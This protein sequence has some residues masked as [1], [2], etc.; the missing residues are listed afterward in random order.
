MKSNSI[1]RKLFYG[2]CCLSTATLAYG[3][4]TYIW[5]NQNP[6]ASSAGNLDVSA[7][8]NPNGLPN[9]ANTDVAEWDGSTTGNLALTINSGFGGSSGQPGIQIY[10]NAS[11]TA[12]LQIGPPAGVNAGTPRW[13]GILI[14]NGAGQFVLGDNT[15]NSLEIAWGS[16]FTH[17]LENDSTNPAIV[18][19]NIKW[20]MGGGGTHFYD[21]TGTGDWIV[22]SYIDNDNSAGSGVWKGG[23]NTGTGTLYWYGTNVPNAAVSGTVVNGGLTIYNGKVVLETYNLLTTPNISLDPNQNGG[24]MMEYNA[25]LTNTSL[26]VGGPGSMSGTISGVGPIQVNAGSLSLSGFNT[27]TG[28]NYLTGGE[29]IV[30]RGE[31]L[32]VNGP[33][34]IGG[35]ISFAGGTLGYSTANSYDYSPRFDTTPGQA[36]SFDVPSGV[37]VNFAT[38]LTSSGGTLAK[39]GAGT[40]TLAAAN[41]YSGLTTVSA[42]TLVIQGTLGHG[43]IT[44]GD[45]QT[46]GVF[47]NGTPLQPAALTLGA[48]TSASLEFLNLTNTTTAPIAVSG[49]I[50]AAGPINVNVNSGVFKTIGATFPLISWGSGSAPA[51]NNP[52]TVSG[53]AGVL[54]T[55]GNSIILTI[56]ATPY[57]WTGGTSGNWTTSAT[58]NWQQSGSAIVWQNGVLTLFDDSAQ[59][60]TNVTITGDLL[61]GSVSVNNSLLQYSIASSAGNLIDGSSGLTKSGNSTLTLTGGANAYTGVTSVGGGTLI[62]S[63]LANGG[64]PSDIGAS[65]SAAANLVLNG[66][67]LQYLGSGAAINRQFSVGT[68]GGTLDSSGTGALNLTANQALGF[69]G[70]GVHTLTLTGSDASGDTLTANIGDSSGGATSLTKSGSGIWTLLGTNTYSGTTTILG[71]GEL[72]IGNG[73]GSGTIGSGNIYNDG[74]SLDFDSAATLTVNGVISGNGSLTNDGTGTTILLNNNTY[75]GATV[76]NAGTLQLG[77]GGGTGTLTGGGSITNNSKMVFDSTASFF[78]VGN[79]IHGTGNVEVK[80]GTVKYVGNND[81]TGWTLIDSGAIFTPDDNN[82][83]NTGTLSTSV[84]TN[85]GTLRLEGYTTRTAMYAN[86]VGTGK[87]QVGAT[88]ANF[89]QGDEVLGGTNTYT[90]GTYIGETHLVLGDGSTP[91]AGSIVGNVYFVNNFEDAGDGGRRLK[92]DR[93]GGDDFV[94]SGNIVTNFSSAQNNLGIVE[95]DGGDTVTLTGNNTYGSGTDITAGGIQ[96]GNGGTSGSIGTGAVTDDGYLIWNLSSTTTFGGAITGSGTF[97]KFGSGSLTLTSTNLAY[98]GATTVS[99]G[100]LIVTGQVVPSTVALGGGDVDME[101]GTLIVGG[102]GTVVTNF[103]GGNLNI[104]A[105]TMVFT[106]NKSLAASNTVFAVTNVA[107]QNAGSINITGGTIKL[108]NAGPALKVGDKFTLF[109]VS[110]SGQ[111]NLSG[112]VTFVTPGFG[113]NSSNLGVDGSVTVTSATPAPTIT[114]TVSSGNLNMS[115]PANWEGGVLLQVQTNNLGTGLSSTNWYTIPGTDAGDTYSAPVNSKNRSVF[116]RLIG[117]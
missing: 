58:G 15:A 73:G 77:N 79:G 114:A 43:N 74:S 68:L 82:T 85:N 1:I 62:V 32:G 29:L 17:T 19:P 51:V 21:F 24:T 86:I 6:V 13:N 81:Y 72:R 34:G 18:E 41:T 88:G 36:Y 27:Y 106:I 11:Q 108:V 16:A 96:V 91:G 105:G 87:L 55:N 93:P 60:N 37:S 28:S 44:V 83:G 7:N 40:L 101:G 90:G 31:N 67:T 33:L 45:G 35:V 3:Q 54:S 53:A 80:A 115:W 103:V 70:S 107:N 39:L 49:A 38:G 110:Y 4:T 95:Q 50:T 20:R 84:I 100:T 23:V 66:G 59:G 65:S 113:V 98:T 111:I 75:S 46:L 61:P 26:T 14:D 57:V 102:I 10:M 47:E 99:N 25:P 112:P 92:F 64:L 9:P 117:Q 5:T 89:D 48:T 52:P 104:D 109:P 12:N 94:F 22:Y 56:T 76:I 97:T 30:N 42:G 116:Y 63:T 71:G 78:Y 69:S 2:L 8:W